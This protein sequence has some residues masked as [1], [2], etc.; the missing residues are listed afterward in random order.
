MNK[1][2][3]MNYYPAPDVSIVK[4]SVDKFNAVAANREYS[5]IPSLQE[6][7][8]LAAKL[9]SQDTRIIVQQVRALEV[10]LDNS[11]V[12]NV[13]D[14]WVRI[15]ESS[16]NKDVQAPALVNLAKTYT[17]KLN[18]I[19]NDVGA[20]K[21]EV[22]RRVTE[23]A[24]LNLEHYSDP[25][26]AYDAAKLLELEQEA[27]TLQSEQDELLADKQTLTAAVKVLQSKSWVDHVK[28][29]LP[30]AQQIETLVSVA[31]VPKVDAQLVTIALDRATLYL[32]F[33]SGGF[34][35]SS[36]IEARNK[37]I[38][39]LAALQI[40]EDKNSDSV[41]SLKAREAK[42]IRHAE[43]VGAREV[44]VSNMSLVNDGLDMFVSNLRSITEP[45]L[46]TMQH[47]TAT[48]DE[49]QKHLQKFTR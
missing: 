40:Q 6:R 28:E 25:L 33:F 16:I 49:F 23:G 36:M 47:Y 31:L 13:I 39:K 43:L 9:L 20:A 1:D 34:K 45:G 7:L 32:E 30:T 11:G 46:L 35:L 41:Q 19:I 42:I 29:L 24:T 5:F 48:I 10:T 26:L 12:T 37:V 2:F 21:E 22:T 17:K 44:W 15:T 4:A 3:S 38:D 18:R 8:T 14:Q 27:V